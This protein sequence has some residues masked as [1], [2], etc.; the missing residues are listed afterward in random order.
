[1]RGMKAIEAKNY[2]IILTFQ[3][4]KVKIRLEITLSGFLWVPSDEGL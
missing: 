1:V 2:L 3:I 4:S